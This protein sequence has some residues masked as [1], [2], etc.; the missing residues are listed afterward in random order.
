MAQAILAGNPEMKHF[1]IILEGK[2][3]THSKKHSHLWALSKSRQASNKESS[4]LETRKSAATAQ[5]QQQGQPKREPFLDGFSPNFAPKE[6]CR[7]STINTSPR[8]TDLY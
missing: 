5:Q 1:H 8:E 4:L 6:I 3:L 2:L 7:T